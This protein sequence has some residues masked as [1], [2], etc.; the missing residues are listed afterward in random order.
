MGAP[1]TPARCCKARP[2]VKKTQ[3]K[4]L[5]GQEEEEEEEESVP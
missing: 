4:I 3:K 1:A 5:E 2:A